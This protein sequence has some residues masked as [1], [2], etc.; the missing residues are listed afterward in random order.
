M[1]STLRMGL[2]L[3]AA[4]VFGLVSRLPAADTKPDFS[5]Q[6]KMNAEKSDFGPLPAPSSRTDKIEHKEP[7]LKMTRIQSSEQ[8]ETTSEWDCTTDGKE[9]KVEIRG[10]PLRI[11]T[12]VRWDGDALA[13]DHK[14]SFNDMEVQIKEKWTLSE[15]RKVITIK[16]NL[17]SP[18]GEAEQTIVLEKQ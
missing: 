1:K 14:G 2:P 3:L 7:S 5:G 17:S 18:Q 10:A 6:W 13:F 16:R 8:G 11:K 4:L 15:D 9:C 12:T